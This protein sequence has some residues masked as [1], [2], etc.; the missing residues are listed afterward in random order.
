M[1]CANCGAAMELIESRRYFRCR[2]CGSYHFPTTVE[3]EGIRVSGVGANAPGCPVCELPMA[4]AVLDEEH[5]VDFCTTCRGVL[6]PRVA[7]ATATNK[8]RAWATSPPAEPLPVDR[9]ELRR[10]LTCPK[11]RGRFETYPHLGPGN[12]VIDNC[13]RCDLIW[14]DFGEL[15]QI[16]QA[17]GSDRGSRQLPRVDEEY[18]RGGPSPA[19]PDDD[20][21]DD[22]WF[23][24]RRRTSTLALLFG[25]LGD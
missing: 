4:H 5:P 22:D 1:N 13:V 19:S 24:L 9:S 11:C 21:E 15:R 2:H 25:I 3:T 20:A 17:P 14:L 16:E 8:R 7:F 10:Q 6:L 18:I 23:R 12:V